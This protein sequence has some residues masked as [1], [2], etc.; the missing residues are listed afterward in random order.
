M[1]VKIVNGEIVQDNSASSSVS[2]S[3]QQNL[4][5]QQN[6]SAA[7]PSDSSTPPSTVTGFGSG[8]FNIMGRQIPS[9]SLMA[10]S[11]LITLIFGFKGMLV[12]LL[13]LGLLY[14]LHFFVSEN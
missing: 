8:S 12:M 2:S 7:S 6:E 5:V 9:W 10:G 1:P 11:F 4:H 13:L 14:V 3:G